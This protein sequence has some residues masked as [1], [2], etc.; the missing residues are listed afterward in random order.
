MDGQTEVTNRALGNMLR[1]L[2]GENIRQWDAH[3]CQAEFAHNHATKRSSGFSPFQVVY[4]LL[5]RGP[6]ELTAVPDPRRMHGQSY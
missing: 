2:V 1:C 4:S 5:T 6:L 3:L